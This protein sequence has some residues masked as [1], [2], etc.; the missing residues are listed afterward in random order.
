[1]NKIR[2]LAILG[3]IKIT[4]KKNIDNRIFIYYKF[5]K[6]HP[7]WWIVIISFLIHETYISFKEHLIDEIEDLKECANNEECVVVSNTK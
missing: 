3:I 2:L 6:W 1:M 7:F 5:R 4:R